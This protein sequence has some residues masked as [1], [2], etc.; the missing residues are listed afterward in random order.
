VEGRREFLEIEV[1]LR[2]LVH[3]VGRHFTYPQ[4]EHGNHV[5]LFGSGKVTAWIDNYPQVC[6]DALR[7]LQA[8][9]DGSQTPDDKRGNTLAS[10]Q[11][12][13]LNLQTAT[14]E[15]GPLLVQEWASVFGGGRNTASKELKKLAGQ[16]QAR[17]ATGRRGWFISRS[18]LPA[19]Q[20]N[21]AE[22]L[23]LKRLK[24]DHKP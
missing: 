22:E 8:V 14:D 4:V 21:K 13:Q 10:S 16:N 9:V 7:V 20:A 5:V 15:I 6:C 12:P 17:P 11:L 23:L 18:A 2:F 24:M 1:W 3:A 19:P